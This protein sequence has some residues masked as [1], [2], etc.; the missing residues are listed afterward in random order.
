M[1]LYAVTFD[2]TPDY[3]EAENFAAAIQ[4]WRAHLIA[5]NAPGDFDETIEP[6]SVALVHDAP[7]L[8][9]ARG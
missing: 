6:E 3:V 1:K 4:I 8:R 9:G 2:G 5:T 7:V